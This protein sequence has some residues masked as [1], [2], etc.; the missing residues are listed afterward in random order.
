VYPLVVVI[1]AVSVTVTSPG[2]D[3]CAKIEGEK[4]QTMINAVTVTNSMHQATVSL[5]V[6][7]LKEPKV[8]NAK[9]Q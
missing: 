8:V 5:L 4:E 1:H 6:H 9:P 2:V 3:I 7:N